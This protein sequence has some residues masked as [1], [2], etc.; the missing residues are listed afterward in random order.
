[1]GGES[2]DRTQSNAKGSHEPPEGASFAANG[3]RRR[4]S[5]PRPPCRIMEF[6]RTMTLASRA[7]F[8]LSYAAS[9]TTISRR[10]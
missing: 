8:P 9:I 10:G 6:P 5:N 3:V 1:M 2:K 7:L 4:D